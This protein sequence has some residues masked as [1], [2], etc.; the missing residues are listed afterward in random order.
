MTASPDTRYDPAPHW[1]AIQ[2]LCDRTGAAPT[3][4]RDLFGSEFSR[5]GMGAKIG[6]YV[7]V[8]TESNVRARL[9]RK[10]RLSAGPTRT[11]VSVR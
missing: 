8:L 1:R 10:A 9:L 7:A 4:V 3:E 11:S 5:L 2:S 6:A